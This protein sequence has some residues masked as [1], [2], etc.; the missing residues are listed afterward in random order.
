[1]SR[2]ALI[3]LALLAALVRVGWEVEV[4]GADGA[5]G[6]LA[7]HL[8]GDE[9]AYDA[10]ARDVAADRVE[11][12]RAFYQE[13]FYAWS[14]GQLY[15]LWPPD[16]LEALPA[17]VP[18]ANVHR[19]I[20]WAQHALGVLLVLLVALLG[21][22][23]GGA[24]VGGLS[25]LFAALSAPLVFHEAQLLKATLGLLVFVLCLQLWLDVLQGKRRAAWLG[26]CLGVGLMLRGNLYLMLGLVL[27]SL[28]LPLGLQARRPRA[29]VLVLVLA[30][31][32]VSPL[33]LANLSR[34]EFVLS[35]YQA[36]TNVAIGQPDDDDPTHGLIYEPLRAGRGD[37]Q[38]EEVDAVAVAEQASG[39]TLSGPEVSSWWWREVARRLRAHP[40]TALQRV[41]YKLAH[42]VHGDEVADVKDLAFQRRAIPWLD[43]PL[44]DL[45]WFGAWGLLGA[46]LLPWRRRPDLLVLRLGLL[47]VGV[48][49]ALFYVMGRYRLTAAPCL[50]ILSA[51]WL[52]HVVTHWRGWA[53]TA[54]AAVLVITLGSPWALASW[55]LP[56][57]VHGD[58]VSFA[59]AASAAR[60]AALASTDGNSA[61]AQRE[62]ALNWSREAVRVAPLFPAARVSLW[63]TLGMRS[64]HWAPDKRAIADA[65][66]RLLLLLEGLRTDTP[67]LS[68][69]DGPLAAVQALASQLGARASRSSG[70]DFVAPLLPEA[71]AAVARDLVDD[72]AALALLDRGLA[73]DP[74]AELL[75]ADRGRRLR[76]AER[77]AE[78]VLAYERAVELGLQ[79][80]ELLNNFANALRDLARWDDALAR[81][82]Q[83][84]E[85]APGHPG[86]LANRAKAE[87]LRAAATPEQP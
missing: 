75:H 55:E 74:E 73:L 32:A 54:R 26:A 18:H 33:T 6:T 2:G 76:H 20:L 79:S 46:L 8:L 42:L 48:T 13:P 37:A 34:G 80:A 22:R 29:A 16:E 7:R 9:R 12:T 14:L 77:P 83:A 59:N 56:S 65:A 64:E 57:R 40:L 63:R 39:R 52:H 3:A 71:L 85:L 5:Q 30:L 36:A 62:S 51:A 23:V 10:L 41:G 68:V 45:R 28:L 50:W 11:R 67:V 31:L 70:L 60:S 44:S 35:T 1:M 58:H 87:A 43:T 47:T 78:A 84:L 15:K 72:E 25:G 81:Y 69:I 21:A 38:F 82:D 61:R 49:L 27:V 53:W 24:W 17:A 4:T 19:A 66:W 86:V